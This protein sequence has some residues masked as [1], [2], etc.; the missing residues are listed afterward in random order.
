MKLVKQQIGHGKWFLNTDLFL[1][2]KFDF[3]S[4]IWEGGVVI[5]P[6]SF[7]SDGPEDNLGYEL[8][9]SLLGWLMI[10]SDPFFYRLLLL[11]VTFF[12]QK[13]IDY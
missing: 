12:I 8:G 3:I 9:K 11:V 7:G 4:K 13:M 10:P 1:I 5:T 6:C 2:T